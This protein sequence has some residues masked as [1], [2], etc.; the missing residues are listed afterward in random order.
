MVKIIISKLILKLTPNKIKEIY[1][2]SQKYK[3]DQLLNNAHLSYAQEG[4]DLVLNKLLGKRDRGV[5]IDVGANHPKRFS[6]TYLFYKKGW[7]GINVEPNP[8]L[9]KLLQEHRPND[10]N[11]NIGVNNEKDNLEYYMFNEPAL[12]TFSIEEKDQYLLNPNYHLIDTIKVEVRTLD[13]IIENQNEINI[14]KIDFLSID[15]EGF[16]LKV[17]KSINL[18]KYKPEIILIEILNIK[19]IEEVFQN[20]IYSYLKSNNYNLILRTGNTFFFKTK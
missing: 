6:N 16:D 1:N 19:T 13:E 5:Y 7:R 10:L 15:A 20:D 4:E 17:L 8:N 12:N 14:S 11:F 2:F 3:L 9:F 18:K